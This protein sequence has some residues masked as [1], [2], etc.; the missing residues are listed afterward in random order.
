MIEHLV[1]REAMSKFVRLTA[2]IQ[3]DHPAALEF[4]RLFQD[5]L[6]CGASGALCPVC[7]EGAC[8]ERTFGDATGREE[9]GG[10][11]SAPPRAG[12]KS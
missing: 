11:S 10:G 7:G 4:R 1:S 2:L 12:D 5:Q 6:R 3:A 9:R 8:L